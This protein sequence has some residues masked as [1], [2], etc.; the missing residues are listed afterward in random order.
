MPGVFCRASAGVVGYAVIA[1][2]LL[3]GLTPAAD[4][5]AFNGGAGGDLLVGTAGADVL[6]G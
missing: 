6:R 5:R 2:L 4:A 1:G 3:L